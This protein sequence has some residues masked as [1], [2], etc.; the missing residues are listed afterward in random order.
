M[1]GGKALEVRRTAAEAS[2]HGKGNGGADLAAVPARWVE[3]AADTP[4]S[5]VLEAQEGADHPP[6]KLG[7]QPVTQAGQ[8]KKQTQEQV[9][10]AAGGQ[11]ERQQVEPSRQL[12][13]PKP[14]VKEAPLAAQAVSQRR[15]AHAL[16]PAAR[17][18]GVLL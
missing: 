1:V 10:A 11:L 13:L 5:L 7:P 9:Q 12:V 2:Q 16:A 6:P 18:A 3:E 8:Q 14:A 15:A 17:R 4:L